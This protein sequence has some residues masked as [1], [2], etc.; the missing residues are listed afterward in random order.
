MRGVHDATRTL[1]R[2]ASRRLRREAV[3][4]RQEPADPQVAQD[5]AALVPGIDA[6]RYGVGGRVA[7]GLWCLASVGS[8][9]DRA[10]LTPQDA[11]A[12][13]RLHATGELNVATAILS[14]I[15]GGE[16]N[17]AGGYGSTLGGGRSRSVIGLDDWLAGTLFEDQ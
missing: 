5:S 1:L 13:D 4:V 15:N 3:A 8:H 7:A 2:V 6:R 12:T 10:I 11:V 9:L 14:T 17:S 16:Q